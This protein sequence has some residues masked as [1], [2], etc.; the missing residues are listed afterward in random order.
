VP[1]ARGPAMGADGTRPARAR[2]PS[3]DVEPPLV[4]GRRE[5]VAGVGAQL[6]ERRQAAGLSLRQFAKI[7]GVSASFISQLENGKSQ[8][9]VATLYQICSALGVTV[10]ELFAALGSSAAQPSS[11]ATTSKAPPAPV[12]R[13]DVRGLGS[14]ALAD[15]NAT[16]DVTTPVVAPTQRRKLVLDSGVTWEQLS[17]IRETAVDFMFVRYDVGGS[18]TVDEQLIRHSGVE[19]GYVISG[20]LV[21]TLG[22]D[23]YRV[24]AGEAISF[25]STTP[26]RL[27]NVGKVPVEAIW[28]VHGRNA[29]HEH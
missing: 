20:E 25:D 29:S 28:F 18:S 22:F 8:P 11:P 4:P 10:D 6:R 5:P 2:R 3:A 13:S 23:T 26:H 27:H 17:A 9:S 14:A 7:L 12:S 1:A 15:G 24:R 21:V 19:Y 16:M